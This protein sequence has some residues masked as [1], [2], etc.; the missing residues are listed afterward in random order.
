MKTILAF[1]TLH[2]PDYAAARAYF[3]EV[4]GFEVTEERPG[5]N[6]FV[7]ASGAGLALRTDGGL[8][9]PVGT[10]VSV[11]FIVPNLEQ[12]HAQLVDRGP[13]SW[14][15]RT[16]CLSAARSRFA[17]PVGTGSGSM[18]PERRSGCFTPA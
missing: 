13:T 14:S 11:Y 5:A 18:R 3:T 2:T 7:Q 16:T 8:T 12:Y 10:G 6:A 4:L 1:V 17:P 9:P 15:P